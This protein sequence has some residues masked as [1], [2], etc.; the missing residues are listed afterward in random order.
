MNKTVC[1]PEATPVILA[2]GEAAQKTGDLAQALE[3]V[4]LMA[5]A[6]RAAEDDAGAAILRR[7]DSIS[8]LGTV[9]WRYQDPAALL[10]QSLCIEPPR[11]VKAG[12]GGEKPLRLIHEAALAIQSGKA[13]AI[14]IVGGESQNAIRKARRAKF[15][16][17]WSTRASVADAWGDLEDTSLG[18]QPHVQALGVQ[19]PI[20]VYSMFENA[21]IGAL[22]QTP[23]ES[24]RWSADIWSQYAA[25]AADNPHAWL[26]EHRNDHAIATISQHNP[27]VTFPYTKWMIAN[28]S[29]NQAA[30]VIVTSLA[31]ARSLGAS[32]DQLVF[33]QDGAAAR[34]SSDFLQRPRLDHSPAMDVVLDAAADAVG[35]AQYFDFAELYSCFPVVP[36]LALSRLQRL[37]MRQAV[38]PT[39]TGGLTFFGGPMNNYMTHATCAMVRRLRT[40]TDTTG[41]LYGQGGVMTKHHGLVL[42]SKP[43]TRP[44]SHQYSVQEAADAIRADSPRV[45]DAYVGAAT[46]ETYAT[47]FDRGGQPERGVVVLRSIDGDR[48]IAGVAPEDSHTIDL[49]TDFNASAV[50]AVGMVSERNGQLCWR[51][52]RDDPVAL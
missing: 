7:L 35:G 33:V 42:S 31:F 4:Q 37:G 3:P 8:V 45:I 22:G 48:L 49:L 40:A 46:V 44:L 39:V 28:D 5:A 21:L 47:Y 19:R 38:P 2:T 32:H 27:M 52:M 51:A 25:V 13:Q 14:A 41:L 10:C 50:G 23:T 30:A 29:V 36:K 34:E 20:H 24:M 18:I 11:Q 15:R 6:M 1:K 43:P 17:D 16:F 12:M 26:R 9:S